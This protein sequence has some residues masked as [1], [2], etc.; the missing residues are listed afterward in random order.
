V[1]GAARVLPSLQTHQAL[2]IAAFLGCLLRRRA[3]IPPFCFLSP[4]GLHVVAAP[5]GFVDVFS[6]LTLPVGS[7]TPLF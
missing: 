7:F 2:R 4:L 5:S 6:S 3:W 1:L